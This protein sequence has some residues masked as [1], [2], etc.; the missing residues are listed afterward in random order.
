[1]QLKE[2]NTESTLLSYT[3]AT[4]V[5]QVFLQ[6]EAVVE[7]SK[8]DSTKTKTL[9][10]PGPPLLARKA[11]EEPNLPILFHGHRAGLCFLVVN[12]AS[13]LCLLD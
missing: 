7:K 13:I 5:L 12:A 1:M 6:A 2:M 8:W 3:L 9:A 4:W 10:S 11:T